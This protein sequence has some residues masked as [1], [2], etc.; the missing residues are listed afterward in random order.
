MEDIF[1]YKEIFNDTLSIE[2]NSIFM[3]NFENEIVFA[4]YKVSK[5]HF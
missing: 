3:R 1:N 5:L 4:S 2:K